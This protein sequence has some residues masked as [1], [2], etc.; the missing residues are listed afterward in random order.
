M[1]SGWDGCT[2]DASMYNDAC[3]SDLHIPTG[4]C[5]LADARFGICDS[6]LV[7]YRGVRYHLAEW[8]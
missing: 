3:L 4:K 2:A 8:G 1:L 6:L 5:Y 7:P